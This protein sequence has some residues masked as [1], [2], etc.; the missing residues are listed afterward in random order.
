MNV[1][2]IVGV[3][4]LIDTAHCGVEVRYAAS[5][6]LMQP[7]GGFAALDIGFGR[8]D[9]AILVLDFLLIKFLREVKPEL[10]P[11]LR[12]EVLCMFGSRAYLY[13]DKI[14]CQSRMGHGSKL[15]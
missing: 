1:S 11:V 12:C 14:I 3:P 9:P 4:V 15:H 6:F 5:G 13:A 8:Q 7:H 10:L 2:V